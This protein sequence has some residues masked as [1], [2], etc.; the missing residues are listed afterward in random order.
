MTASF[1]LLVTNTDTWN[2]LY[3]PPRYPGFIPEPTIN[4]G[5]PVQEGAVGC[6]R[7]GNPNRPHQRIGKS[8]SSDCRHTRDKFPHGQKSQEM[9]FLHITSS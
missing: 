9:F 2:I 8:C 7:R 3:L 6:Y 4:G 1:L 5:P